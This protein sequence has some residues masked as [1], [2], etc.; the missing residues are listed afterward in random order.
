M[1]YHV[2][3]SDKYKPIERR[4]HVAGT[5]VYPRHYQKWVQ[6]AGGCALLASTKLVYRDGL[7]LNIGKFKSI[8]VVKSIKLVLVFW[9]LVVSGLEIALY[10]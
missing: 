1:S 6:R 10:N 2:N 8:F 3:G 4:V 9:R 7:C 5:C